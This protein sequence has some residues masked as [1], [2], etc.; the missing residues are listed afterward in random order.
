MQM[1]VKKNHYLKV[2]KKKQAKAAK[3]AGATGNDNNPGSTSNNNNN[4]EENKEEADKKSP[5]NAPNQSPKDTPIEN[6]SIKKVGDFNVMKN[7]LKYKDLKEGDGPEVKSGQEVAVYYVG[8]LANKD[9][10]DK[11]ISGEGFLFH[12]G[13]GDV[14]KGWDEGIKGMK[15]GGKRRLVV[16]AN[17]AYGKQGTDNIPPNSE[18]TFTVEVRKVNA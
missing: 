18:L 15:V 12:L 2:K 6:N 17:L 8:Q 16:P 11:N 14:I 5:K 13:K 3:K 1:Q 9:I 10:F 4:N 7:G